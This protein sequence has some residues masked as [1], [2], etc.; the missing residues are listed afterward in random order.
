V[1]TN[2]HVIELDP[3]QARNIVIENVA[4]KLVNDELNR[5]AQYFNTT[6][7]DQ[8]KVNEVA[9]VMLHAMTNFVTLGQIK[10]SYYIETGQTIKDRNYKLPASLIIKG[11][12][13]PGKDVAILKTNINNAPTVAFGRA[14]ELEIGEDLFL[15]GYPGVVDNNET[16]SQMVME[17]P[18]FATGS[19]SSWQQVAGANWKA[20][21]F[22]GNAAKGNSGGPVF[23]NR[24]EV[25]GMLTF[26]SPDP[27]R[28]A[29][30]QGFNFIVPTNII[31]E[32]I[33]S[34]RIQPSMSAL[35]SVY[36]AGIMN[37]HNEDYYKA[38]SSFS[39][40]QSY[41]KNWPYIGDYL[42]K[43]ANKKLEMPVVVLPTEKKESFLKS[44]MTK[45]DLYGIK[46]YTALIIVLMLLAGIIK[47]FR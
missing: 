2:A 22:D 31:S 14:S 21:G 6:E 8:N 12:S 1:L 13:I 34:A 18:T 19:V 15:L 28:I 44:I 33:R 20:L 24:G 45:L 43:S 42:T 29:L 46:W 26:G 7:V 47:I 37:Y 40:V 36:R 23:N 35:D 9:S 32:Y 10:P 39:F 25:I 38:H 27:N 16:L 3:N 17:E 11:G 4:S 41:Q 30:K 5:Y